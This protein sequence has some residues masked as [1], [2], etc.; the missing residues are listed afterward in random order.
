MCAR[1]ADADQAQHACPYKGNASYW[2]L[3]AGGRVIEDAVWAYLDPIPDCPQI[4]GLMCFYPDKVDAIE[5][6]GGGHGG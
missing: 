4:K 2:S 1:S 6:E 5:V 3:A